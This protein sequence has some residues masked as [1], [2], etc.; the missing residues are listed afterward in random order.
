MQAAAKHVGG[1][2]TEL[3][4][5]MTHVPAPLIAVLV[6]VLPLAPAQASD[7]NAGLGPAVCSLYPWQGSV[8]AYKGR[9]CNW[10]VSEGRKLEQGERLH[11]SI[12]RNPPPNYLAAYRKKD[13][14][15]MDEVKRY[16]PS[17][18]VETVAI[19][20]QGRPTG[21]KMQWRRDD[22]HV[23]V[24][25]YAECDGHYVSMEVLFKPGGGDPSALFDNLMR[26]AIPLISR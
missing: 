5:S 3:I 7:R 24:V 14:G 6:A 10:T 26:S 13:D 9:G 25:G 19:C 21:R 17:V 15:Y 2:E 4:R 23:E 11:L 12:D 16:F 18:V 8:M 20:A 22:G 1:R